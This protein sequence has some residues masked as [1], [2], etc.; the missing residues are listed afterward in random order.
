M[1]CI[2]FTIQFNKS[3]VYVYKCAC[4]YAHKINEWVPKTSAVMLYML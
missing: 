2:F 3:F 1:K 4:A